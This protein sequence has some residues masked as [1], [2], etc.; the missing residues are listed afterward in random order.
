[1]SLLITIPGLIDLKKDITTTFVKLNEWFNA[2]SLCLNCKKTHTH[3]HTHTYSKHLITKSSSF[4]DKVI[5]FKNKLITSTSNSKFLGTVIENS[6]SWKAH[7]DQ[8]IPKLPTA[9]YAITE[10]KPFMSLDILKLVYYSCFHCLIN[11]GIIFWENSSHSI[12][13]FRLQTRVIR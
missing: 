10:I 1:M 7:I 2:N 9:C 5:S 12:H 11:Y 8:F 6:L 3:T 13:I 4:I